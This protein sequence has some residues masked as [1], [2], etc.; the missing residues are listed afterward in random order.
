MEAKSNIQAH[1]QIM[2]LRSRS[3]YSLMRDSTTS[4]KSKDSKYC[5]LQPNAAKQIHQIVSQNL[6]LKGL[7]TPDN[8]RLNENNLYKSK[9]SLAQD[10]AVDKEDLS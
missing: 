4:P 5:K 7:F 2:M 10:A 6:K 1:E 9:T 3:K 8:R